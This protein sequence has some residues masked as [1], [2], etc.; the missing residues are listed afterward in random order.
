MITYLISAFN[1]HSTEQNTTAAHLKHGTGLIRV[2]FWQ[3][4]QCEIEH[5][6]LTIFTSASSCVNGSPAS[7]SRDATTKRPRSGECVTCSASRKI[8]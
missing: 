7:I 6:N 2:S 4:W 3:L 5:S 8:F 1:L